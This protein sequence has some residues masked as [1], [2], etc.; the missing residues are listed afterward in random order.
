[1]SLT[2]EQS[3]AL[4]ELPAVLRELLE[5]ELAAG[6]SI[7]ELGHGHPAAPCGAW[8]RL[9]LPVSSRA[10]LASPELDFYERNT[11]SWSGEFTDARRHFFIL[12][13]PAPEEAE[14]DMQALRE[15]REASQHAA[16]QALWD[17]QRQR[18][19]AAGE[20]VADFQASMA[21]DHERWHDGVGYDCALIQAAGPEERAAIE[22]LLLARG[23]H[24]WRDVEALAALDSDPA[25]ELL[26]KTMQQDDSELAM[27]VL[28]HAPELVD[29]ELRT[30][31]L[32]SALE[33]ADF[34]GG[35]SQALEQAESF[36]PAPVIEALLR[37]VLHRDGTQ[38]VHFVALLLFLH[39]QADSPFDMQQRPYFLQFTTTDPAER[40]R[41][42]EELC[43]RIPSADNIHRST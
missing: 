2:P 36:H 31:A 40:E 27:S 12:E 11:R 17:G 28:R 7:D 9:R 13:P 42:Y 26:R 10:R 14:P 23:V 19:E 32:V 30:R 34:Y 21:I 3:S 15:A 43:R 25:R 37:G 5:A 29:D 41:L 33:G 4:T 18:R 35:L 16:D 39:G 38:A 20:A 8:V 24:D 1:M 6:N 22:S